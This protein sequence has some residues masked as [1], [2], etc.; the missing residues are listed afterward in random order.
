MGIYRYNEELFLKN[1]EENKKVYNFSENICY[2]FNEIAKDNVND[3]NDFIRTKFNILDDKFAN[4]KFF[5]VEHSK[6]Y[7]PTLWANFIEF[8]ETFAY[9]G[10][11]W[12]DLMEIATEEQKEEYFRR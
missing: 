5:V 8:I 12:E 6:Q 9:Q 3:W 4:E 7:S 11:L 2:Y 1:L 10:P